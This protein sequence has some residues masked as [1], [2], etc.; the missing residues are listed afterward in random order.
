MEGLTSFLQIGAFVV[1]MLTLYKG[2]SEYSKNNLFKR[3]KILENLIKKF[4]DDKLYIAKRLLDDFEEFYYEGR[5]IGK[6]Q[7]TD[8]SVLTKP[9]TF[10]H[11]MYISPLRKAKRENSSEKF[12]VEDA[13]KVTTDMV[14]A[15]NTLLYILSKAFPQVNSFTMVHL[16][17]I[18]RNHVGD[19][20][21][22]DEVFFR[23]SFDE[24]LD[25]VLLLTYYLRNE[26]ITMREVNAHFQHYLMKLRK[27]DPIKSYIKV[28]YNLE[29]FEWLFKQLPREEGKSPE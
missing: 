6:D 14:L 8:S 26:I 1:A 23:D 11:S 4:K 28:Y 17:R 5:S 18:L 13:G 29:D 7:E 15:E 27:N 3:A 25:F 16:D 24:L 2:L 10:V 19:V 20:I 9:M 22:A 21:S 12:S